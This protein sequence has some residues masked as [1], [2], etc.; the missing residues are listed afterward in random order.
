MLLEP[1]RLVKRYT[2]DIGYFLYLCLK[3]KSASK[4]EK[5]N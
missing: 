2:I 4:Q 1:K 3:N 5:A